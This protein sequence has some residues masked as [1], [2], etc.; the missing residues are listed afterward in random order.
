[1]KKTMKIFFVCIMSAMMLA[2]CTREKSAKVAASVDKD[3]INAY[4]AFE[5]SKNPRAKVAS[6]DTVSMSEGIWLGNKSV[7]LEHKNK[8]PAQFETDTGVTILLNEPL[9]R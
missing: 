9:I 2:G 3:F 1:M 5:M 8:L 7:V 4:D 6:G